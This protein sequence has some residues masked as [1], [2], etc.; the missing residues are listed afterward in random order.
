MTKQNHDEL[1]IIQVK[2]YSQTDLL[3]M[4]KVSAKIFKTW[5]DPLEKELGPRV[6]RFYTPRQVKIIFQ[7]V[8]M[9]EIFHFS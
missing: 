2:A 4:Y 3:K 9:P 7:R 1:T 6:G 8:G 5:L